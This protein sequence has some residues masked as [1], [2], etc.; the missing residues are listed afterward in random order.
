M[1]SDGDYRDGAS[2][3]AQRGSEDDSR[4]D[5]VGWNEPSVT[6]ALSERFIE[7]R[8]G[9]RIDVRIVA[10][11]LITLEQLREFDPQGFL[12]LVAAARLDE[13]LCDSALIR[14]LNGVVRS[15]GRV[16]PNIRDVLLSAIRESKAGGIELGS[17]VA[18]AEDESA[19]KELRTRSR[20]N[21]KNSLR[22]AERG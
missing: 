21:F 4:H 7:L 15:N 16:L 9:S 18:L 17:P 20:E 2:S 13:P 19:V 14:S 12:K 3:G 5:S 6:T 22:P 11:N 10:A 1:T 8:N